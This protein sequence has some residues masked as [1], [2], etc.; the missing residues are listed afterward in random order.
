MSSPVPRPSGISAQTNVLEVEREL[1]QATSAR[2]QDPARLA[3]AL[4]QAVDA[5]RRSPGAAS[6]V[7]YLPELLGELAETYERLDR[8]DDA[9]ATMRAAIDAGY[10][11]APDPRCRLAEILLRAGRATEAHP[12]FDEVKAETPDDVWLYNNAG[13]EYGAA[14]DHERAVAW[15]TEGLELALA[16]GD[17]ERLVAQMSDLRRES[18]AALGRDLDELEARADAFLAQPQPPKPAWQP[19]QLPGLLAALDPAQG[20]ALAPRAGVP[21]AKSSGARMML[22]LSWFPRDEFAAALDAWPQLA[23]DWGTADHTEY[24]RRL[25]RHLSE[26]PAVHGPI[27][28]APIHI[29]RLRS[30]CSRTGN[31][32][33]SGSARSSYP[34]ELAR[35]ASDELI[36]WPP[37][38]NAPCWCRSGR[39]YKQCCGHPSVAATAA[40]R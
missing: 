23:D 7:F 15:L 31:D 27:C 19:E 13:L 28:I 35:S 10:T 29:D 32:P 17:P 3:A 39:K 24:N 26:M 9:L 40:V 38:R 1:E 18:L 5:C 8:S 33:A 6:D 34:A 25:Q 30:W 2:P 22:A 20:S 36:A 4:E 16:T 37:A 12:I 11:G 21:A 14:G